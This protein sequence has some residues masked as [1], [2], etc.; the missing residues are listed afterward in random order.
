MLKF[1]K[2]QGAGNDFVIIDNRNRVFPVIDRAKIIEKLCHR[3]FGIGADGVMLLEIAADADFKMLYFNADGNESSMCGNGG[4]CIVAFANDLGL[5]EHHCTFI[6]IDGYHKAVFHTPQN[7]ELQMSD[8]TDIELGN[9]FAIL[10]TGSPHYV[11]ILPDQALVNVVEEGRQIRYSAR[12][13]EKGINVNFVSQGLKKLNVLT[14]ERGVEDET[15]ACGTGVTAAVLAINEIQHH[16][17]ENLVQVAVKGG[18]LKVRF[19][20]TGNVY[21]D[22]W[23]IGPAVKVFEGEILL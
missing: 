4:R 9:N 22:I 14:Y 15:Y 6:A 10:D 16:K 23:L 20:K 2:Y 19:K 5:I 13:K 1:Y 3:R 17:S 7:V 21:H 8:V 18:E 11:K 12:F